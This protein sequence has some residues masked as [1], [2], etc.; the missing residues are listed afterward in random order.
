MNRYV[1][2]FVLVSSLAAVAQQLPPVPPT[3]Q[4]ILSG[5]ACQS[6]WNQ[7]N[8]ELQ[9]YN[10]AVAQQK[11]QQQ[12]QTWAQQRQQQVEQ[13]KQQAAAQAEQQKQQA[14]SQA[15]EQAEQEKQEAVTQAAE[16]LQKQIGDLSKH[17]LTLNDQVA[18]LNGQLDD[19]KLQRILMALGSLSLVVLTVF[20]TWKLAVNHAKSNPN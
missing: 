20:G 15:S 3:C 7:Y 12:V 2:V 11:Y 13:E 8:Q 6:L 4:P 16:P 18:V 10:A 19:L 9:Q 14:L 1:T 5:G 17:V